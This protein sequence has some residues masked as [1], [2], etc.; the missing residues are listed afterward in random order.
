MTLRILAAKT[1]SIAALLAV[2][3]PAFA[4]EG[5][6]TFD[7][8]P[9]AKVNA[10][11][12]TKI[13]QAWLDRLRNA[14]VRIPGCSASLVSP[15]GLVLTNNHCVIGCAQDLSTPER[16]YVKNGFLPATRAE[17]RQCPG[18][19]A[20]ILTEISDVTARV[21]QAA[22]DKTGQAF[23]QA[24]DA[25]MA[26]IEKEACSADKSTRCQVVNLY[27]GGQ[28]KLYRYKRYTDVRLAFSPEHAAASFG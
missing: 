13:D 10:A 21:K 3:A 9:I 4:G 11:L 7:A 18:A 15:D 12:G 6:W 19:T 8:F 20:E 25:E 14:A 22:A 17:E 23:T 26:A 27:R 5:M 16:D 28:F 2:A 24:R 1:A